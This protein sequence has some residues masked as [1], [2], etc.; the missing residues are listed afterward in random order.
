MHPTLPQREGEDLGNTQDHNG[1]YYVRELYEAA[2]KGGG[3]VD[4]G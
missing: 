2:K 4:F 3:F 1:V